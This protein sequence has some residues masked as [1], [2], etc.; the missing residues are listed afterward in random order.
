V[1]TQL[2]ALGATLAAGAIAIGA[3]VSL[4]HSGTAHAPGASARIVKAAPVARPLPKEVTG[5]VSNN[6]AAFD[7]ACGC[8]PNVAVHYARWDDNPDA[9]RKLAISMTARGAAPLLEISPFSTSLKGIA[10]GKTDK[11]IRE[12]ATMIRDLKTPVLISFAPE[13]NGG[14]YSWGS[15]HVQPADEVEAWRHVVS[16][17]RQAG[18]GNARW[19]WIVNQLWP[20]SGDIRA[21]WPGASYVDEVGIDGYFKKATDTFGSVFTPTI[22]AVRALAPGKPVLITET[23]ASPKTNKSHAVSAIIQGVRQY[24]LKGFVWFDIDQSATPSNSHADWTLEHAPAALAGFKAD[25]N[26]HR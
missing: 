24:G 1:K 9:S 13:A 2:A 19:V 20:G 17:F 15:G 14:W 3:T 11:W 5:V 16:V 23:G 12:Y 22:K 8:E 21:L 25:T 10:A 7:A 18:A 6:L 4:H 26:S